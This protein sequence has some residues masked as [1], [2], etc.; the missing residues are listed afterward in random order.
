MTFEQILF[1][2]FAGIVVG[3]AVS[4]L[5]QRNPLYSAFSLITTFVGLACLYVTLKAQFLG[6]VQ[7][8]VYAGAIMMLFVFV[9]MLLNIRDEDTAVDPNRFLVY[10]TIPLGATLLGALLYVVTKVNLAQASGDEGGTVERV[11]ASLL[12]KYL[13]PFEATSVLI[14]MAVVGALHLAKREKE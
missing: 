12:T 8:V 3:G 4:V 13:L 1:I 9:I 6:V 11:G 7:I 10:L 2:L 5:L 14:L